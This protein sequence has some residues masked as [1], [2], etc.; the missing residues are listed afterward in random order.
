MFSRW[1]GGWEHLG[2]NLVWARSF[3]YPSHPGS[4]SD[5]PYKHLP[6]YFSI[7]LSYSSQKI[8]VACNLD[9]LFSFPWGLDLPPL[10]AAWLFLLP[11]T[12]H[13]SCPHH[14]TT[15]PGAGQG[16]VDRCLKTGGALTWCSVHSGK[17]GLRIK[18]LKTGYLIHRVL[19][20][21]FKSHPKLTLHFPCTCKYVL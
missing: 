12:A 11:R 9:C 6:P 1:E 5:Q 7:V 18:L 14:H 16:N 20:P 3:H 13:F 21:V 4:W 17:E 2:A 19:N 15:S 8:W 10:L